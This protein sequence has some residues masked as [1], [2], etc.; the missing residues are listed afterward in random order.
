[1]MQVLGLGPPSYG[2]GATIRIGREMLCL[3]YAGFFRYFKRK[4]CAVSENVFL[5]LLYIYTF[6]IASFHFFCEL[7]DLGSKLGLQTA[8]FWIWLPEQQSPQNLRA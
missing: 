6:P 5:F 3:P 8:Q 7:N 1:M 2:I 4:Y